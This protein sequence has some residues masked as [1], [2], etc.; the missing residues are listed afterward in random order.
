MHT[1]SLLILW[2]EA[3]FVTKETSKYRT[4]LG[5]RHQRIDKEHTA[6]EGRKPRMKTGRGRNKRKK[7]TKKESKKETKK[8]ENDKEEGHNE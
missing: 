6:Q 1:F 2:Y 4:G 5:R 7:G 3:F 8:K